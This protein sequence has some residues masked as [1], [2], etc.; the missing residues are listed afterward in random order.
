LHLQLRYKTGSKN[1][2]LI[3]SPPPAGI[4]KGKIALSMEEN[5]N[6]GQLA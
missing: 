1:E 3:D 2:G 5:N 4:K 6:G